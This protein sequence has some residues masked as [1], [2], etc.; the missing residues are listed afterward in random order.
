MGFQELV[1]DGNKF[2]SIS[3]WILGNCWSWAILNFQIVLKIHL[4]PTL[5]LK[6]L[7]FLWLLEKNKYLV[8]VALVHFL[9]CGPDKIPDPWAVIC[10]QQ[11]LDVSSEEMRKSLPKTQFC[12]WQTSM[13]ISLS[14]L[15]SVK[16][17]GLNCHPPGINQGCVWPHKKSCRNFWFLAQS[18]AKGA[19][20]LLL[21]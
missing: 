5:P 9:L 21:V 1:M 14:I 17:C 4:R 13:Q 2:F 16:K 7:G 15:L 12:S 3:N 20:I 11:N 6:S 10:W 18:H 19:W 8:S